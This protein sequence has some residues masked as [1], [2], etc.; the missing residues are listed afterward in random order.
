MIYF[1]YA[2]TTK[3][4]PE[5]IK[6]HNKINQEY[7]YNSETL[8]EEGEKA[9]ALYNEAC[10]QIINTLKLNNK[11]ILFTSG[12]TEANN[13][14]IYGYLNKYYK[15]PKE[16]ITTVFE[17]ASTL[18]VYKDLEKKGFKVT[19]L[20]PDNKNIISLKEL[21]DVINSNTVLLSIMWVNNVTG[22]IFPI[23][24]IIEIK[25]KHP[26]LKLH[27]DMVQGFSKIEPDFNYNDIDFLT[28]S[29]HK[30]HGIKGSGLL[31]YP[32]NV[33][34]SFLQGG[35]QQDGIRPGTLDLAGAITTAKVIKQNNID[36]KKRYNEVNKLH[37][38]LINGLKNYD[39]LILNLKYHKSPYILNIVF[40]NLKGETALH[41]LDEK[42]IIVGTGSACN[43]S[44]KEQELSLIYTLDDASLAINSIR[45]SLS[46]ETT[47][48][49]LDILI[50]ELGLIGK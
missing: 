38:Y 14:A 46:E 31:I 11:K 20:K 2:A 34:L 25:K 36:I 37:D 35:H 3:P 26:R 12:A 22:F 15:E 33:E 13:T 18:N 48:Q 4:D 29:S 42:G 47:Y 44:S 50:K 49:E 40:K 23:K 21:E 24:D 8:Y 43:S 45:I 27:V 9:K 10:N 5:I 7:W 16:I 6:L 41:S 1:D 30:L 39:H 28:F 19:Y 32:N 17:H